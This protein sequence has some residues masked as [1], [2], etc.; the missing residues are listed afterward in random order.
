MLLRLLWLS[1]V[2][3]LCTSTAYGATIVIDRASNQ[4]YIVGKIVPGD[5]E[6]FK[7][8]LR[9]GTEPVNAV[10]IVSP[11]GSV[12]EAIQIGRL[13]RRL[14][15]PTNAPS[16]ASFAPEARKFVCST[17]ARFDRTVS[18]TCVSACF[19]IWAA[20]VQRSGND[21]HIHRISYDRD[22]YGTLS[23]SEASAKYQEA[24]QIVRVY[25]REMEIPDSIF[26]T[27]VSMP[28]Y[29]T[30]PLK[31]A[32]SLTWPPS[33]GEWLT[34]RCGPPTRARDST[35]EFNQ[36]GGATTSALKAF[37]AEKD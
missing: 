33:F 30:V 35:C 25:L 3:T 10:N 11:G 16:L 13:I 26:E 8:S 37:R 4:L 5:Y 2:V 23:P 27:M 22:F 15:L 24:L 29:A 9:N 34:A 12:V 7:F 20:G 19:L 32:N 36:V 21:I 14:S 28:S 17:A 31:E 1:L 6:S 18:C